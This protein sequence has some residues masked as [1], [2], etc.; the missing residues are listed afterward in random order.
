MYSATRKFPTV[1]LYTDIIDILMW[2][3]MHIFRLLK[4]NARQENHEIFG[5][6]TS[7]NGLMVYTRIVVPADIKV[8]LLVDEIRQ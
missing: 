1:A 5:V 6:L 3:A 7:P 2:F 8:I 4:L